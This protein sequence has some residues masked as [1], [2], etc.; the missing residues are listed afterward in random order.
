MK[1]FV[2]RYLSNNYLNNLNCLHI[3]YFLNLNKKLF[4]NF[5]GRSK[6]TTGP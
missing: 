1:I 5:H 6:I 4:K 2:I 3:N